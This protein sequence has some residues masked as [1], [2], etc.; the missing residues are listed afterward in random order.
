M[1]RVTVN[2]LNTPPVFPPQADRTVDELTLL[3][4]TN[5]ATDNDIPVSTLTYALAVMNHEDDSFVPNAA[6]SPNGVITWTPNEAQGPGSY[7]FVTV[8]DDGSLRSTNIFR[9]TVNELNTP[10]VLPRQPDR[11]VH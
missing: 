3:T 2:D 7:V 1:F 11:T 8:A 6:I 9:V 4:V 5:T 10:P